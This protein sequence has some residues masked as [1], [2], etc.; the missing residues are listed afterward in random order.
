MSQVCPLLFRQIDANTVKVTATMV[1]SMVIIYLMT[2]YLAILWFMIF[3]FTIRLS[4]YKHYSPLFR[5]AEWIQ[6]LAKLPTKM[7]DAGAKRLAAFFGLFFM[8]A[9]V[10]SHIINWTAGI[11]IFA[12]IFISCV[13]LDLLFNYCIACKVYALAKKIYPKGFM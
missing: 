8:V 5:S 4:G 13:V 11:W 1:M 9:M 12:I 7:E 3:D 10:V 2:S 6:Q